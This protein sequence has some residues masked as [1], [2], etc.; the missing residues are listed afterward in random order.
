MLMMPSHSTQL[1][2]PIRM[3]MERETMRTPMMTTTEYLMLMM[4][5][6]ST[7]LKIL[8][9]METERETMRTPTTMVMVIQTQ[10]KLQ[11]E[12][13]LLMLRI[14]QAIVIRMGF[15]MLMKSRA[16]MVM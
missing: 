8:I 11:Q 15:L 13:T 1:K 12:Q 7:Q 2:I 14:I 16:P 6:H 5:S 10:S 3:E 9:R 4:P